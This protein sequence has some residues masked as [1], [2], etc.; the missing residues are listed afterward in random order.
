MPGRTVKPEPIDLRVRV[1]LLGGAEIYHMLDA[2]E[3][4]FGHLFKVLAD[5]DS[6]IPREGGCERYARVLARIALEEKL[7]PLDRGAVAALTEHGAR[8]AGHKGKLT[9]RFGRLAD[10]AR[11]GAFLATKDRRK[12]VGADD[13]AAAIRRS[14]RRSDLPARRFRSLL[15]EGTIRVETSGMAVGQINGLAVMSTGPLTFGFPARITAARIN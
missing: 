1:I 12:V 11:E 7:P 10:I 15:S 8:I 2:Y 13:V 3:A 4:D 9:T 14:K 6:E 5:F